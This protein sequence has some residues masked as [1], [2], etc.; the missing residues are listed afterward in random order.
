MMLFFCDFDYMD[1]QYCSLP[2][3]VL[4]QITGPIKGYESQKF[5]ARNAKRQGSASERNRRIEKIPRNEGHG[6][7]NFE[8]T[9]NNL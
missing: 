5:D 1:F 8:T 3:F 9:C 6:D 7:C 2:G 4:E